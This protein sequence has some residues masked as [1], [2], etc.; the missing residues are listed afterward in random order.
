MIKD[1]ILTSEHLSDFN[2]FMVTSS[3]KARRMN[4]FNTL[5]IFAEIT[6]VF[7]VIDIF[8][9]SGYITIIG[10][11]LAIV[12]LL[13]YPKFLKNR[14]ILILKNINKTSLSKN[15]KFE[16]TDEYISFYEIQNQD[17]T[18]FSFNDVSEIY[19]CKNIFIIFLFEK[20]HI[21]LPV[22]DDVKK[23]I[24]LVAKN[25]NKHILKFKNLD[26]KSIVGF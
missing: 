4:I 12:W 20:I 26:Y 18:R 2:A 10:L 19:E 6:I 11:I 15:M 3:K 25:S 1:I 24:S 5:G 8:V 9:K 14:Q 16:V 23:M 22:D 7:F 17:I 21:V 13:F